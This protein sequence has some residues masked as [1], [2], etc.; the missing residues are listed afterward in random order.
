MMRRVALG[1]GLFGTIQRTAGTTVVMKVEGRMDELN[2]FDDALPDM[3]ASTMIG[4][5]DVVSERP[6]RTR[7]HRDF[8]ILPDALYKRTA[9]NPGGVVTGRYSGNDW[10]VASAASGSSK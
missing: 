4:N 1:C 9:R 3:V 8:R 5:V 10:E 2:T 7:M 6:L